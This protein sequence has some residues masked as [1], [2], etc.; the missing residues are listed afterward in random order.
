MKNKKVLGT[1]LITVVLI[2][3]AAGA[4][5]F[6]RD[7]NTEIQAQYVENNEGQEV[8]LQMFE[9]EEQAKEEVL[10][11][12]SQKEE[13]TIDKG[14]L[15][16]QIE[17]SKD[18]LQEN[19]VNTTSGNENYIEL[20]HH[21]AF[22]IALGEKYDSDDNK[23]VQ[24]AKEIHT[25]LINLLQEGEDKAAEEKLIEELQDISDETMTELVDNI[26]E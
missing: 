3:F 19:L 5:F 12:D 17:T 20:L 6:G 25:Y 23:L 7:K 2:Y 10:L 26:M 24:T 14:E 1:I 11:I 13:E 21:S 16:S 15:L 9:A 18:Y 22:F 4:I 8:E